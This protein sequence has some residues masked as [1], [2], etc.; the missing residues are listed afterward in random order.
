MFGGGPSGSAGSVVV[1]S[2]VGRFAGVVGFG[3][4]GFSGVGVVGFGGELVVGRFAGVVG[5]G[6]G[7]FGGGGFS[8]GGF[9]G[10]GVVGFGG[11]GLSG[12]GRPSRGRGRAVVRVRHLASAGCGHES[13]TDNK[14]ECKATSWDH[15]S[16]RTSGISPSPGGEPVSCTALPSTSRDS[17][18]TASTRGVGL[19]WRQAGHARLRGGY[20]PEADRTAA[21]W[22]GPRE[23]D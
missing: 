5:F 2:V 13:H 19:P 20:C 8:G 23:G 21:G 15:H 6:G 9:S 12:V 4:G 22:S 7:G 11:G 10:V 16:L 18:T 3:G 1:S 14:N 17:P